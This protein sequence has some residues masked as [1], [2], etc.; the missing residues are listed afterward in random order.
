MKRI[1]LFICLLLVFQFAGCGVKS[2]DPVQK[3][4]EQPVSYGALD[5]LFRELADEGL[6][7][8]ETLQKITAENRETLLSY[9][10]T[11]F[12]AGNL[13][14][15]TY[16]DG[17]P[18]YL[19]FY[20]W[21]N[22]LEG[23]TIPLETETPQEYWLVWSEMAEHSAGGE[24]YPVSTL[25]MELLQRRLP[26]TE[27]ELDALF[28]EL[29]HNGQRTNETLQLLKAREPDL[30]FSYLVK[31]FLDGEL[32]DCQLNDGSIGTVKFGAWNLG[33]EA[34][35]SPIFSPQ[36]Y[37]EEWSGYAWTLYERNGYEA[38]MELG[39]TRSALAGKLI[40]EFYNQ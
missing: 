36:Q 16:R 25:Y 34:I 7:T 32:Q 12:I 40:E 35:E 18:E 5:D 22:L 10:M 3:L 8:N 26:S 29:A 11:D 20:V 2:A 33:M 23:E 27:E 15:C 28:E 1:F 24:N 9:L 21:D 19:K 13:E 14:G 37:W 30:L 31:E 39:N 4:K 6:M 38:L 17:S